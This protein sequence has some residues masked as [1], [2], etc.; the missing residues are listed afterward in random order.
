MIKR[1]WAQALLL[2]LSMSL[3]GRRLFLLALFPTTNQRKPFKGREEQGREEQNRED[4]IKR[5]LYTTFASFNGVSIASLV[6]FDSF[7]N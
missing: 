4:S 3:Q 6:S 2:R 1:P 5:R 7:V